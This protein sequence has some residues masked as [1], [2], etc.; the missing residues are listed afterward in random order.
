MLKPKPLVV[1][2]VVL[3]ALGLG[4]G[5]LAARMYVRY[6]EEHGHALYNKAEVERTLN[7]GDTTAAASYL[8]WAEFHFGNAEEIEGFAI[9]VA[10]VAA[11]L[12]APGL[13][14]SARLYWVGIHSNSSS[15]AVRAPPAVAAD[16][17]GRRSRRATTRPKPHPSH[18][19]RRS[20]V[21]VSYSR[22]DQHFARDL[23]GRLSAEGREVW[24]DWRDIPV[25]ADWKQEIY[26]AID[27]ANTFVFIISPD[28]VTS[29]VCLAELEHAASSGKRIIPVLHRDA[30][31]GAIPP[32]VAALHWVFYRDQDDPGAAFTNLTHALDFDINWIRFH[33]RLL[34]RAKEWDENQRDDSFLLMGTDLDDAQNRLARATSSQPQVN[35]LQTAYLTASRDVSL[36]RQRK[37]V[38]GFYLA[39]IAFG[40]ILAAVTYVPAFNEITESGLVYLAPIWILALTFGS[41]GLLLARPTLGKAAAVTGVAAAVMVVL[42]STVWPML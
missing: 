37:Q 35:S 9:V 11:A 15:F 29:D 4:A 38:R 5:L 22:K 31:S 7:L 23:V 10:I 30:P 33:T 2:A 27:A 36:V 14:L 26:H 6:M 24:I 16:S 12:L 28:S 21:F 20:D 41:G 39:S 42:Y 1:V 3:V 19:G 17:E 13:A 25:T 32:V 40:L 8:N 34:V 18:R